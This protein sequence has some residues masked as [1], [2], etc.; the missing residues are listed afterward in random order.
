[1]IL[2]RLSRRIAISIKKADPDGPGTVEILEYELGLRLNWYTGLIFTVILGWAFGTFFG[3]LITLFS[4]VIL[5]KFSG[6]VHLPITICSIV[7][8]VVASIIPL[9]NLDFVT[10]LLLN[11]ISLI[12][13]L[14][15]APNEFE[16]VNPTSWDPWLKWISAALVAMN[17]VA[18]SPEI[19]LAFFI[20]AILIL[21]VWTKHEG[22]G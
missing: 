8:G 2:E 7:T 17:F 5:R 1:M 13:V 19:T 10:I 20:Q 3:S 22:G 6:G 21:P 4:F 9:I 15:Y 16:Y 18:K 12:I 14:L 11:I